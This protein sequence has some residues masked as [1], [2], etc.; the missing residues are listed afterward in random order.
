MQSGNNIEPNHSFGTY[1]RPSILQHL[2]INIK[3]AD[4][5]VKVSNVGLSNSLTTAVEFYDVAYIVV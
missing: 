1:A 4:M 3:C 2:H 5:D